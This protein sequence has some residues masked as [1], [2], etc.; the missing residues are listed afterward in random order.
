[1]T[2]LAYTLLALATIILISAI[3][4]GSVVGIVGS[5]LAIV[6]CVGQLRAVR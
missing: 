4:H 3:A 2:P 1:M 5:A 6:L